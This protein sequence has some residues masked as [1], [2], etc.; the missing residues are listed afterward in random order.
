[1][2]LEYLF[3]YCAP[4]RRSDRTVIEMILSWTREEA[5]L[6][7]GNWQGAS[8][9]INRQP[10]FRSSGFTALA[11]SPSSEPVDV[12]Q[13]FCRLLAQTA[14]AYQQACGH[15]V[16]W[17]R[18]EVEP[19]RGSAMIVFEHEETSVGEQAGLAALLL[20]EEAF[21]EVEFDLGERRPEREFSAFIEQFKK[22]ATSLVQPK[23]TGAIISAAGKLGVPVIKLERDPYEAVKG[24]FRIR[25]NSMLM[26]GH[27][28]HRQVIDGTF[29]IE[30]SGKAAPLLGTG[31]QT[32]QAAQSLGIPAVA[33]GDNV[34]P[35]HS[36]LLAG[37]E[38]C[39]LK[40]LRT[41]DLETS[42]ISGDIVSMC[43]QASHALDVGMLEVQLQCVSNPGQPVSLS[44]ARVV[45][46]NP[47]PR[48]DELCGDAEQVMADAAERFVKWLVPAGAGSRIPIAAVTG[49][50]GKT[51]TSRMIARIMQAC[52]W[53]TG[54]QCT[55]G[56][57]F[58][59][60][61]L[62]SG[63][64]STLMGHYRLFEDRRVEAAVLETHHRGMAEY[65]FAFDW[66]DVAVCTNV[67]HD[68]IG[69]SNIHSV[70]EMG[71]L[72][73]SLPERA[74]K[75]AVLNADNP[76]CLAMAAHLSVPVCLVSTRLSAVELQSTDPAPIYLCVLEHIDGQDQAVFYSASGQEPRRSVIM[77]VAHIP[78]TFDGMAKFNISNALQAISASKVL[79][80]ADDRIRE[81]MSGFSMGV[82]NTPGRI[83]FYEGLPF[84]VLVD[85][86]HNPDG[87]LQLADFA[88]K[89]EVTGKRIVAFSSFR[90]DETIY[91]ATDS[92]SGR[93]DHYFVKEYGLPPGYKSV[94]FPRPKGMV[95][96]MICKRLAE[97]G[98]ADQDV[99]VISDEMEAV[100][101]ALNYAQEGDLVVLMLGYT[102]MEVIEEFMS[103]YVQQYRARHT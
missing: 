56:R 92:I 3:Y 60:E 10:D 28:A 74:R 71:V 95:I 32:L 84:R 70:A 88:N 26:L 53:Q 36:L 73:R 90:S 46:I 29:A 30:R 55:D 35:S 42:G 27:C 100:E 9:H 23:D 6:I 57:Y 44:G 101:A 50:N 40:D 39:F 61:L 91:G 68:H 59:G 47:A 54:M 97:N 58:N 76:Q 62:E 11:V 15:R 99:T 63:D 4:N 45:R 22:H 5:S 52:G 25:M 94:V 41:G 2:K 81:A 38:P 78:A 31:H 103:N 96:N 93:Y 16:D 80:V 86:A 7:S 43:A 37:H 83:N 12:L 51:T 98:I 49:T 75:C 82:S 21:H 102:G 89:L 34:Q 24:D 65:G 18:I 33:P 77:P 67:T 1:M 20:M 19:G 66:C 8:E 17:H 14:L 48:L 13:G 79:G 69:Y 87:A 85:F 64:S 72:K